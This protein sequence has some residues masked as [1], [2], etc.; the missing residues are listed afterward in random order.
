MSI[1]IYI[2]KGNKNYKENKLLRELQPIIDAKLQSNPEL[3]ESFVPAKNF[4]ELKALHQMY[5][6]EEVDFQEIEN[7]MSKKGE[8][9]DFEESQ[10]DNDIMIEDD[11]FEDDGTFID[12]LNREEPI[13]RDYVTDGGISE[14]MGQSTGPIRTDFAEP[15]S[16]EEAFEL[17]GDDNEIR[18]KSEPQSNQKQTKQDKPK[19]EPLNPDFDT[20]SSGKKKRSTMKFAKY[21]VEAVCALAEKG[22]VWYANADINEARLVE[23]EINGEMDLSLLVTLENGQEATV[24]QFFQQQCLLAEQLSKFEDEEK[25]DMAECLAEVFLEKGIAPTATQEAL[26]VI[27]GIAVKKG[28]MLI[29]LKAQTN[30]LLTQL[31]AMGPTMSANNN[32]YREPYY[33]PQPQPQPQNYEPQEVPVEQAYF[34]QPSIDSLEIE[35]VIETKE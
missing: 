15:V 28:A 22:F 29:G 18:E 21:I 33:E 35:Q 31:R 19:R 1:K 17:P 7:D 2:K 23:Y 6:S 27:M 10:N 24:K 9:E 13:V 3:A 11:S 14:D 20:M 34:E 25:K 32:E 16:W 8:V 4:D 30:S 26:I 12:P 5:V